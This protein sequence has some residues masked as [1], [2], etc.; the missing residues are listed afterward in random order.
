MKASHILI[1]L[2]SALIYSCHKK[3]VKNSK[4]SIALENLKNKTIDTIPKTFLEK[5]KTNKYFDLIIKNNKI[6]KKDIIRV[7]ENQTGIEYNEIILDKNLTL[8]QF[9]M[10]EEIQYDYY[11]SNSVVIFK[12]VIPINKAHYN[13][14][15]KDWNND[16]KPDLITY[17]E[18]WEGGGGGTEYY[19]SQT[20]YKIEK[21]TIID[22]VTLPI[23]N[24]LCQDGKVS[25]KEKYEY[26]YVNNE[27][28][29]K[30]IYGKGDCDKNE[31]KVIDSTVSSVKQLNN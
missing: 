1:V 19:K 22:F 12:K 13:F 31:I 9:I 24:S 10:K 26:K 3:E 11:F 23:E 29:T 4:K 6:L 30:K 28:N 7:I 5:Y 20:I 17:Y 18:Q 8:C 27:L 25:F 2:F 21:D 15:Y 16:S 14:E